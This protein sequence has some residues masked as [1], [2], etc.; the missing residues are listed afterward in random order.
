MHFHT[1]SLEF[2]KVFKPCKSRSVLLHDKV[3]ATH[4][5]INRVLSHL[6]HILYFNTYI[7][8][9]PWLLYPDSDIHKKKKRPRAK[10]PLF[11]SSLEVSMYDSIP[12]VSYQCD[13][14]TPHICSDVI[15][16]SLWVRG[17]NSL[18]LKLKE[19]SVFIF[20]SNKN[21][22]SHCW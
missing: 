1:R 11:D 18:R 15:I 4:I 7:Y 14:Q 8:S 10:V 13:S 6:N 22:Q 21:I 3:N 16:G 9:V 19:K 20:P 17:V 12:K 2:I 5:I